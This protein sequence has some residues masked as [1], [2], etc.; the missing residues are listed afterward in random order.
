MRKTDSGS[1]SARGIVTN[2]RKFLAGITAT[3]LGLI[4]GSASRSANKAAASGSIGYVAVQGA[5][6]FAHPSNLTPLLYMDEGV[7]VDVLFGPHEGLYEIRYYGTDGWIWADYL[8]MDG[9]AA[10]AGNIGG[11]EEPPVTEDSASAPAPVANAAERWIDVNRS[12]GLVSLMI[13][14]D[15]I[16]SFWGSLGWE[17]TDDGFY[18]TANGSYNI[19]GFDYSL[20][21]TEYADNYITHWVAFDPIRFNGF[22]SYTKNKNGEILPNGAGR[23]A[24]CVAL[25]PGDIDQL[26]DFSEMGMRVEVHW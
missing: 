9:Y 13:G 22:H 12:S 23:T 3:S 1:A 8:S 20:H 11:G 16:A 17:A 26:W 6:L 21:Y 14:N 18:A 4:A 24:G 7:A 2:R 25:A 15:A 5:E 10:P 19:Y